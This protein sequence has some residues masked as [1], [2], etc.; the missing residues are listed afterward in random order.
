MLTHEQRRKGWCPG[1]LSPMQTKDGLLVR[2][3]VSGGILG[4]D[5]MRRLAAASRACGNGLIDL[6]QRGNLQLR[7]VSHESYPHL[8]SMLDALGLIDD[9]PGAEA[10]RNVMVSPLAGLGAAIDVGPIGRALEA[11][12]VAAADLHRLPGKF[13]F[14]IDDGGPLS[15]ADEAA[16][17]RFEYRPRCEAFAISIG[18]AAGDAIGLGACAP[19]QVVEMALRLARAFLALGAELPQPPRRMVELAS[20]S[21]AGAIAAAAGLR[22]APAQDSFAFQSASPIGLA[23]IEGVA[24]FGAGAPLGRLSADMLHAAAE[25]AESFASGEIRLTPWRALILPRVDPRSGA[26]LERHFAAARFIVARDDPRL[27]VAACGGAPACEHASTQ[28]HADALAL[29]RIARRLD[30]EGIVLHVSGCPKG[31]ARPRPTPVTLVGD[32]GR[33]DLVLAGMA[34]DPGVAHNLTLAD[35]RDALEALARGDG[36][37]PS[38]APQ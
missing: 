34:F 1:A 36:V 30:G 15:L 20:A 24:F 33:Y 23:A 10:V 37:S 28:T 21:G 29:A 19:E 7:G 27:A 4:A 31:C 17:V 26:A 25:A 6:S 22:L 13:G 16:D 3:R 35:A 18:G 12:L 38:R 5:A 14:L 32:Q 2:L 9:D 8:V 11:A